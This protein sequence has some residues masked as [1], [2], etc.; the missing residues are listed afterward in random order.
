MNRTKLRAL[1]VEMNEE[2]YLMDDI[3]E[4]LSGVHGLYYSS[5]YL[6]RLLKEPEPMIKYS[7]VDDYE[8][9]YLKGEIV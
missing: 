6:H 5:Y 4:Y 2:G 8:E 9:R 3:Q 1:V 7:R